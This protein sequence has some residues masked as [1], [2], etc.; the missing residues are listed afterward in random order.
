MSDNEERAMRR[1]ME[2]AEVDKTRRADRS[3]DRWR[4]LM[5]NLRG[6]TNGPK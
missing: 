2:E 1:E 4:R 6:L 3:L 5:Q